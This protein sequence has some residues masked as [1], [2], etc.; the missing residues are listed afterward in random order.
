[1]KDTPEDPPTSGLVAGKYEV[2]RLIGRGG[3]GAVWEGRH[4][5]LGTKVAIKFI[6]AEYADSVDARRR[7][8]NE[9][10]AAARIESKHAINIHDHGATDDG[11]PYIVMELLQGEPL[12]Q[13]IERMKRVTLPDTAR[14]IRQVA[15][16]LARAHELGIVHRDLKPENIFLVRTPDEDDEIAKV[17][18]FGIAKFKKVEGG[19]ASVTSSTKTGAVLG[20]PFY[21]SP[22]QARGLNE[23]DHRSDLWSLGVIAF[24]CVTGVLPFEGVS[25][26]DLLVKICTSPTAVPSMTVPTLSPSFDAWFARALEKEPA[27]RFQSAMELAEA[28]SYAAGLSVKRPASSLPPSVDVVASARTSPHTN[29]ANATS[30]PL[31]TSARGSITPKRSVVVWGAGALVLGSAIGGVAFLTLAP[32]AST[33]HG[34][35]IVAAPKPVTESDPSGAPAIVTTPAASE[36]AIDAG[37][38]SDITLAIDAGI[39]DLSE[40]PAANAHHR[41]APKPA[42]SASSAASSSAP[43][44][45]SSAP[46]AASAAPSTGKPAP[47]PAPSSNPAS[48][49]PGDDGS[50]GS[51]RLRSWRFAGPSSLRCSPFSSRPARP[52]AGGATPIAPP[53]ASSTCKA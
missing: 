24:K 17:L 25:I 3:M 8:E 7:F 31:T 12:D 39:V 26:G 34:A 43:A 32:R 33:A 2:V 4:A 27:K 21:M 40:L 41:H 16:A 14:I 19:S 6:D 10:K 5:T 23:I 52:G 36:L 22:E 35:A 44:A 29:P 28:L 51:C 9:A 15:R 49:D 37:M 13:R 48:L 50:R 11:K 53:R 30:A 45:A 42:P 20:T 1:M 18:D 38:P 47:K 46:A